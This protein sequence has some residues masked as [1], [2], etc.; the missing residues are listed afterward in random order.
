MKN[1]LFLTLLI[2]FTACQNSENTNEES[3]D[4]DS[5]TR[6][7]MEHNDSEESKPLLSPPDSASITVGDLTVKVTFGSPS[8]RDRVIWDGLVPYNKVWRIG[9][10]EATT[11]AV[12]KNVMIKD[13]ALPAG[14]YGLFTIPNEDEWIVI[15]NKVWDQWGA[16]EYND[17]EDI[18]RFSVK[19]EMV[20]E[21]KERMDF[22]LEEADGAV[23]VI[24]RWE[25]LMFSF[26]INPV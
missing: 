9:A 11:L 22:D 18:L 3:S 5:N 10:N 20:S 19:P 4:A 17:K 24:F 1:L 21:S 23:K 16:Y 14:R 6:T 12:S 2:A 7:M 25:K 15:L 13:Q 8:V 26:L